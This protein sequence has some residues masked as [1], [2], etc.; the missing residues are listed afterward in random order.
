MNTREGTDGTACQNHQKTM[1]GLLRTQK[2]PVGL[3][4]DSKAH[5]SQ[6]SPPTRRSSVSLGAGMATFLFFVF[7]GCIFINLLY[8]DLKK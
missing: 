2:T 8:Q 4:H 1:A 7:M 6:Q 5:L 3:D